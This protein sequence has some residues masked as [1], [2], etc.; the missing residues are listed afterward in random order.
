M[1]LNKFVNMPA[2]ATEAKIKPASAAR[3]H[4]F[5]NKHKTNATLP[6]ISHGWLDPKYVT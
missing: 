3:R 5:N 6:Q 4:I 1:A 2:A